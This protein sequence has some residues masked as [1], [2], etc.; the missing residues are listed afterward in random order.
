MEGGKKGRDGDSEK[1][2]LQAGP[3]ECIADEEVGEELRDVPE[4]V[5]FQP[6]NHGV[7]LLKGPE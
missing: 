7:L 6:M 5:R 3:R 1:Y 2:S 4:L